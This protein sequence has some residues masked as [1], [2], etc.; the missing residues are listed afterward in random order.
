MKSSIRTVAL[1]GVVTVCAAGLA[2]AST[3]ATKPASKG[4]AQH[5]AM[6]HGQGWEIF[7][8]QFDA[9]KDGKVSKEEFMAKKPGFDH[10]D[11]NKDGMVTADEIKALPAAQ[12]HGATGQNFI[13]KFDANKDG[14]VT[15]EE[16]DAKRSQGFGKMD[17]N[18]DGFVTKDEFP[19]Q[20]GGA[21]G[22]E[23]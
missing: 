11:T 9:N 6:H 19:S 3:P 17:K 20:G 13:E 2:L 16:F 21:D 18:A 8:G 7:A 10:A 1:M 5:A 23:M 14:K 15:P 12:K 4:K 22:L